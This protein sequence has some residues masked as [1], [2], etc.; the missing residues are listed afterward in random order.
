MRRLL[1]R[2]LSRS[3]PTNSA[4]QGSSNRSS[5]KG[6]ASGTAG[7]YSAGRPFSPSTRTTSPSTA[8]ARPLRL[9]TP[10]AERS[11][12]CSASPTRQFVAAFREAAHPPAPRPSPGSLSRGRL[13]AAAA[14]PRPLRLSARGSLTSPQ[15]HHGAD[16]ARARHRAA[17]RVASPPIPPITALPS[18]TT[19]TDVTARPPRADNNDRDGAA[20]LALASAAPHPHEEGA[21]SLERCHLS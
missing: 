12:S 20:C 6:A 5:R 11:A 7:P 3:R 18:Q 17:A 19:A 2:R 1:A 13:P 8:T 15:P 4:S 14:L 10:L 16:R 21:T 9:S